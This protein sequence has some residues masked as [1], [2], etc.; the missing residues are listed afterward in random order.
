MTQG[1][2][3]ETALCAIEAGLSV[4]PIRL[5]GS[6]APAVASWKQYQVRL[7]TKEEIDSWFG[8]E[9][10]GLAIIAG[11]VSGN[12]E[13]LDIEGK[14]M[15]A[16]KWMELIDLANKT[17]MSETFR[18]LVDGYVEYTPSGGLHILYRV[19]GTVSGNLKLARDP[20]LAPEGDSRKDTIIETRGEGGYAIIAPTVDSILG[21]W[22]VDNGSFDTIPVLTLDELEA[23]HDLCKFLDKTPIEESKSNNPLERGI[24]EITPGDAFNA[25]NNWHT[26]LAS[27]GWTFLY[28]HGKIQYWRRPGKDKG[29]SATVGAT[30]SGR[31]LVVHSS[32]TDF[33]V[34]PSSYDLFGALTVL[35]YGGDFHAAA[36]ALA[37]QGF[38]SRAQGGLSGPTLPSP[39]LGGGGGTDTG[40]GTSETLLDRMRARLYRGDDIKNIPLAAP[41]IEGYLNVGTT[42]VMYGPPKNGKSF[43]ALDMAAR[44]SLGMQWAGKKVERKPVLYLLAEGT[45]GFSNR[46]AAWCKYNEVESLP[47]LWLLT[48]PVRM[49][50]KENVGNLMALIDEVA[51][52]NG[53]PGLIVIDTLARVMAG[54]NENDASDMGVLIHHA[55]II[56]DHTVATT[57]LVHHSGKDE[58]K[59]S[60]GHSSLLGALDSEFKISREDNRITLEAT[61]QR[62]L[63]TNDSAVSFLL[64]SYE[65]SAVVKL[66]VGF[67]DGVTIVQTQQTKMIEIS[68]F[69]QEMGESFTR[70]ALRKQI[71]CKTQ[72]LIDALQALVNQGFVVKETKAGRG[73][74]YV[75]RHV[76]PYE[77]QGL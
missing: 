13:I 11:K 71:N 12:L 7:P 57:M 41:L 35:E 37:A 20:A 39:G 66:D 38:G 65:Q 14:A 27:H 68:R 9:L 18:K 33:K 10:H 40:E 58:T 60:R 75:Y 62:D 77:P 43:I 15:D 6:K 44:V 45:G 63:D 46:Y 21:N 69:L 16:D 23:V 4:I 31:H 51:D 3:H 26:L 49:L 67:V 52:A 22:H 32:S 76:M 25:T 42:A 34:S 56:R 47:D 36:K 1:L 17:G 59:G 30:K 2:V 50:D 54:G 5:D 55:D 70:E 73:G 74:G 61:A 53:M 72:T 29:A 8:T 28:Q 19:D 64:T 48:Y 24:G